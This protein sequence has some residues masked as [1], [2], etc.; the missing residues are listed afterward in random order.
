[1]DSSITNSG[2]SINVGATS[3][4]S[5]PGT[6]TRYGWLDDYQSG[7]YDNLPHEE[8]YSGYRDWSRSANADELYEGTYHGYQGLQEDQ[9]RGVAADLYSY[10][11]ERGL[12]LSDLE[13]TN[14]D[15]QQWNA[16]DLARVTGRAYGYSGTREQEQEQHEKKEED[17]ESGGI[18]KPLV[19]LALAGALAFA[20][21]RVL[22]GKSDKEDNERNED[23]GS[24]SYQAST[25][26]AVPI[27]DYSVDTTQDYTGSASISTESAYGTSTAS[28][29]GADITFDETTGVV[30]DQ[31]TGLTSDYSDR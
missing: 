19:G 23:R 26:S 27:T 11:Q 13:L 10:T 22:G 15:Y 3:H 31:S 18:P 9:L 29:F 14:N 5:T 12:D 7:N 6:S 16:Q 2:N 24:T 1:M 28:D 20:A 8:I 21:S 4:G 17:K 30:T 25:Q